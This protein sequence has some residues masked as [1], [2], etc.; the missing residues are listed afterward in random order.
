MAATRELVFTK[1]RRGAIERVVNFLLAFSRR[2][3]ENGHD[4]P[5]VDL[6]MTRTDIGDFLGLSVETVSRTFTKLKKL[7]LIELS[8][9]NHLRFV[10]IEKLQNLAD[11]EDEA[12]GAKS[13]TSRRRSTASLAYITIAAPR[14]RW[15]AKAVGNSFY[16]LTAH[17]R[18]KCAADLLPV[19]HQV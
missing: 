11:S 10:D 17:V 8:R 19:E 2:N 6:P 14:L 9:A 13:T 15:R 5:R 18:D 12:P 3:G 16:S 4:S 7:R 1:G